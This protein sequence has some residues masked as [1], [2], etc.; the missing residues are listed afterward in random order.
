MDVTTQR[1]CLSV[2]AAGLFAGAA[3]AVGWSVSAIDGGASGMSRNNVPVAEI[4]Q[5]AGES[6]SSNDVSIASR[7]LRRPLQDPPPPP[8][9]Q[10]EPVP[11][12]VEAPTPQPR[13]DV[14]LVGTIIQ[15][16]QSLA[17]VSDSTGA[18][19][20]K[21]IGE[22]LELSTQGIT[23]QRIEPEKVTLLYQERETIVE[24]TRPGDARTEVDG[25]E[26]RPARPGA[27]AKRRRNQ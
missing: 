2:L 26:A 1:R 14:T 12:I 16:D 24:L 4:D 27:G 25:Q 3:G 21:G 10:P 17:I 23:V 18:F 20:V 8:P 5:A 7:A 6:E 19:D 13:L 15:P 22:A 11:Q 9:P